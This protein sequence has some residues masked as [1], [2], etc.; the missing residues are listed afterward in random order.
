MMCC[1]ERRTVNALI[2]PLLLRGWYSDP[3]PAKQ[4]L[5]PDKAGDGM[6]EA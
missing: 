2:A 6:G 3:A 1:T 5:G 4:G